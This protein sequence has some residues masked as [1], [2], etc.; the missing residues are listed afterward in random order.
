MINRPRNRTARTAVERCAS[1]PAV[2]R[3]AL[4]RLAFASG[5]PAR[6]CACL[7]AKD[8]L[9]SRFAALLVRGKCKRRRAMDTESLS[10]DRLGTAR[11]RFQLFNGFHLNVLDCDSITR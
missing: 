11:L 6:T 5:A 10:A 7:L 9:H 3:P 1:S 2:D 4:R 8:V